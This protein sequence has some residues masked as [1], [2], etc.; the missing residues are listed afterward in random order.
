MDKPIRMDKIYTVALPHY[1]AEGNE[2]YTMFKE[3]NRIIDYTNGP[4]LL[5]IIKK[6][7]SLVETKEF[8]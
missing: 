5:D 7:F 1:V 3:C 8:N 6:F 2:E 4:L